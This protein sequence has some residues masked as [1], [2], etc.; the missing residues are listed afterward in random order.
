MRH[1][2]N[3]LLAAQ[4]LMLPALAVQAATCS[5]GSNDL[6][7]GAVL[8]GKMA[9]G[10]AAVFV[11]CNSTAPPETVNYSVTISAGNGSSYS[12]RRMSLIGGGSTPVNYN[13]FTDSSRSQV[14]GDGTAGTNVVAGSL[15]VVSASSSANATLPVYGRI[16]ASQQSEAG[17]YGDLLVITLNF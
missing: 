15:M 1:K 5:L 17:D 16:F 3:I 6:G 9:D 14:W 7:F 2:L 10:S 11:A 4:L 12:P 13:L 8:P